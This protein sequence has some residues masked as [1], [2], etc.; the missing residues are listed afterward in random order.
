MSNMIDGPGIVIE[1][2][3][4]TSENE[5]I[6]RPDNVPSR[7]FVLHEPKSGVYACYCFQG[8]HGLAAFSSE[9]YAYRF[10]E[11][12]PDV[13]GFKAEEKSFEEVLGIAFERRMVAG[14]PIA[15]VMVLDSITDPVVVDI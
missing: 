6:S 1:D 14:I 11:F 7:L 13:S 10:G 8:K 9:G 3:P 5:R 15:C 2:A 12:I 4:I